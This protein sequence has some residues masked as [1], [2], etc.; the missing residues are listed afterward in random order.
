MTTRLTLAAPALLALTLAVAPGAAAD[1]PEPLHD[2]IDAAAQRL[3]TADPVAASKW[4]TGGAITDPARVRVVL[5]QVSTDAQ[6]NGV[7]TDF[8]TEVFTDQINATEGIQYTRFAG[9]KFDPATAPVSAPDLSAS[10]AVIDGLNHRMVTEIAAQWPLLQS[11][12]CAAELAAT[13]AAVAA[14]RSFDDL[15]RE[16]LDSATRSY[17]GPG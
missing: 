17:C 5:D 8:V 6:S 12:A 7:P 16:A 15:Y 11:P 9:W 4:L 10:R 14:E 1:S 2:L 3:Q 13:T